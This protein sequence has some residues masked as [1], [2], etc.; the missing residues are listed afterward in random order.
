[1]SKEKILYKAQKFL[2]SDPECLSYHITA[3]V[4][5][6][7]G[8]ACADISIGDDRRIVQFSADNDTEE[9]DSL[10]ASLDAFKI[11]LSGVREKPLEKRRKAQRNIEHRS[12]LCKNKKDESFLQWSIEPMWSEDENERAGACWADLTLSSWGR[13]VTLDYGFDVNKVNYQRAM[14]SLSTLI[15]VIRVARDTQ[16][17]AQK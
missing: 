2:S 5:K 4:R 17:E 7:G 10:L 11:A 13:R 12:W 6:W 3:M 1:M 9:L 8:D 16:I 14:K 15:T